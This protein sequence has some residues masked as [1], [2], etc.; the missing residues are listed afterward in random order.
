VLELMQRVTL[1]PSHAQPLFAPRITVHLRDG[2]SYSR[3]ASGAE[4]IW[5]FS[6]QARRIREI[7][8]GVPV[9][10][11]QF[12]EL[13]AACGRLDELPRADEVVRLTLATR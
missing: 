6:E 5:D 3:Q 7:I 12:D 11:S 2:R 1:I 13:I 8:P 9:P 4:F 10:A